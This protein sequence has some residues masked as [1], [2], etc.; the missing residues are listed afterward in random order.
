M[1]N[2]YLDGYIGKLTA[3][4]D[5]KHFDLVEMMRGMVKQIVLWTDIPVSMA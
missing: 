4:G 3:N 1:L 2:I 5:K